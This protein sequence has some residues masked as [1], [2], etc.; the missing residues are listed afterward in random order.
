MYDAYPIAL[1]PVKERFDF[2][3]SVVDDL[4]CPMHIEPTY[5]RALPFDG[6]V[7]AT[8]LGGIRL[9]HVA[10]L[11]CRVSRR[12]EDIAR[13]PTPGYLVKF[14][15]KGRSIWTQRG[16]TVQLQP[17]DF[18]ICS[19]VEPY[20][21]RFLEPYS[22][23]VLALSDGTM[24]E[25]A[26]NPQQFL[27][28]RMNGEDPDCGLLTEFVSQVVARMGRLSPPMMGRVEANILDLLG[29]VLAS[30]TQKKPHS[31][32]Q[33][34]QL[35]KSYIHKHV[36]NPELSAAAIAN[37]L[38]ISIRYVHWL[39]RDEP[40]TIGRY[41]RALRVR[42]CRRALESEP[43]SGLPLKD[44]ALHW[45]FYDQSHMTRCFR[46]EIKLTPKAVIA[47]ARRSRSEE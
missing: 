20:S 41:I 1:K 28:V 29:A 17:C 11:P 13:I 22:M 7:G 19:I 33:H 10:T 34:L 24:R 30:R 16:R 46:E 23:S 15:L 31:R 12:R 44:L 26:P 21:L 2:F 35:I 45:G 38:G 25:L 14:Q 42:E 39:F 3:R 40:Q 32:P 9:A 47:G 5:P 4:F 36:L 27:G 37:A 43:D 6:T 8:N 18:V